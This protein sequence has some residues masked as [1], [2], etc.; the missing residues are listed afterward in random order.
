M[1]IPITDWSVIQ[2]ATP[3]PPRAY[4]HQISSLIRVNYF[5]VTLPCLWHYLCW[6]FLFLVNLRVFWKSWI[7]NTSLSPSISVC[8]MSVSSIRM[9]LPDL[10]PDFLM[11]PFYGF[12]IT[13]DNSMVITIAVVWSWVFTVLPASKDAGKWCYF[14]WSNE[15]W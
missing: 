2:I 14:S 9:K 10:L 8:I 13:V 12:F 1:E 7:G 11:S 4:V 6:T 5:F 3:K 15:S